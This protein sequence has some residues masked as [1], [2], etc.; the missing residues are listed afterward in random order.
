MTAEVNF[1][2]DGLWYVVRFN[3]DADLVR[4]IKRL[5]AF[6]RRWQPESKS[7]RVDGYY[8]RRIAYEMAALGYFVTGLEPEPESRKQQRNGDM[9]CSSRC[10]Q[11]AYYRRTRGGRAAK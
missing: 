6:A 4:V 1:H 7:W 8:A 9:Y 5:P 3:Y 11:R 2:P 10:R